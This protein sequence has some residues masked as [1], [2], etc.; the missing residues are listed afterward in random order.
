[1]R[2]ADILKIILVIAIVIILFTVYEKYFSPEI[3]NTTM[4]EEIKTG[5]VND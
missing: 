5:N 2:I 3:K 1:M 4:E